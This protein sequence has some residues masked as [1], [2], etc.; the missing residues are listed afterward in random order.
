MS[1]GAGAS[2]GTL[3]Q[4]LDYESGAAPPTSRSEAAR[5]EE[6]Q[7]RERELEQ[8]ERDL[9]QR[10]EHIRKHG[11]NNWPFC[12]CCC[13]NGNDTSAGQMTARL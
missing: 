12:E 2:T 3:G 4:E 11:R 7:R 9:T 1:K 5:M 10:A 8:R 6:L 13:E